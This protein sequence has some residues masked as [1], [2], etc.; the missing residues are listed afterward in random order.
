MS[1]VPGRSWPTLLAWLA[2]LLPITGWLF[3][4]QQ[5]QVVDPTNRAL[6]APDTRDAR[7]LQDLAEVVPSDHVVLLAYAVRGDLPMLPKDAERLADLCRELAGLPNVARCRSL[8]S[9][10]PGLSLCAVALRGTDQA[11]AAAAVVAAARKAC[12]ESLQLRATGLPLLES[13]IAELVTGERQH[14]VPLLAAVLLLAAWVLYRRLGLAIAA[15]LPALLA[16][17]WTGGLAAVLG[18]PLD[19]VGAL[20]DPVLLTIGVATSV[21][22][23][24]AWRRGQRE[25]REPRAAGW[26]AAHIQ[27]TPTLLATATTMVG[28]LSMATSPVPA[29][30]DFGLRAA[31]GVALVHAF[32]FALLP[33]WLAWQR[34]LPAGPD[35]DHDG[36]SA[37][38]VRSLRR[39]AGRITVATAAATALAAAALPGLRADNDPLRLLPLDDACRQDHDALAARLGGVEVFHLLAPAESPGADPARLLGFVAHAQ[40][41][42]GIAGLAGPVLRN[43][44]GDLAVPLLLQ[45]GGSA[46][47]EPLFAEL[48]RGARVLG[49]DGLQPAGVSV[50]I[51][52]DSAAL[53]DS[54]VGSTALA[55]LLLGLGMGVGLRSWRLGLLGLLANV[56][57]CVWVYGGLAWL[58]RPVSVATGMIGCTM[59]GL[60]VDNTLHLLHRYRELRSE[61]DRRAAVVGA[62]QAVGRPMWLSS[63]LLVLGFATAATSRLSTTIEFALLACSTIAIALVGCGVLLPLA[64]ARP[65]R[66]PAP[67]LG[68]SHGL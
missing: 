66:P 32:T 59:L 67:S 68:D 9:P 48:D 65:G 8:P 45:P 13:R 53:M 31:F 35:P 60:I 27:R 51:A 46:L 55:L 1:P 7:N 5:R 33:E 26:F 24:E 57:P 38:W 6:K 52:R 14:L 43:A 4:A 28:L 25:G 42:S 62:L 29:V 3:L 44:E 41:Q 56:L 58:D 2:V 36:A 16:I 47:R 34:P 49:L 54:L 17:V 12:P 22:F 23:V 64:L 40:L 19:P 50:Q 18:H 61:V 30:V 15:L 39:Y 11:N 37:R 21:H 63:G 10:D 20:L